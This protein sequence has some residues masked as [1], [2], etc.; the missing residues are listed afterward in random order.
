MISLIK[1]IWNLVRRG[2]WRELF[3]TPT[4]NGGIQ[5]FRYVFVGGIATVVDWGLLYVFEHLLRAMIPGDMMMTASKYIAAA[6][7]FG[8]GLFVNYFLSRAFVFNAQSSRAKSRTAEFLGHAL[9]GVIGLGLTE[10]LIFLGSLLS[11]HYMIAKVAATVIVFFWN[12]LARK[13]FVYR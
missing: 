7:G 5:F 10:L 13:F 4:T 8:G 11:V 1:D 6:I 3:L 2:K 12:Y 9:V